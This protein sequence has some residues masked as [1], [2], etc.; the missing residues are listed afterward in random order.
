MNEIT[1]TNQDPKLDQSSSLDNAQNSSE[2][3]ATSEGAPAKKEKKRINARKLVKPLATIA[4]AVLLLG[5]LS[6]LIYKNISS[7]VVAKV[8]NSFITRRELNNKLFQIYGSGLLDQ[9]IDEKLI[10]QAI[11]DS[12]VSYS[13]E[14]FDAKIQEV[15]DQIKQ[16]TGMSLED[17]LASQ[18]MSRKDLDKN[19][20]MQLSLEKLL[21]PKIEVSDEEVDSFIEQNGDYLSGETDEEK[22]K[23][24]VDVLLNQKLGEAFQVWLEEQKANAKISSYIE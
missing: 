1:Q 19:I 22:R 8:G 18:N 5:G 23:E 15:S 3:G 17:Y 16:G 14:E 13:Q 2:T 21:A 9:L 11:K 7:L 20:S 12:G 10:S 6:M 4:I 24:A